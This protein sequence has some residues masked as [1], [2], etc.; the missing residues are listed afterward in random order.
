[1]NPYFAT[2]LADERHQELRHAAARMRLAASM[3]KFDP[4][5]PAKPALSLWARVRRRP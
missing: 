2:R 1:M 5:K 3:R 4:N